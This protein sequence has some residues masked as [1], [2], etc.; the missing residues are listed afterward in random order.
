MDIFHLVDKNKVLHTQLRPLKRRLEQSRNTETG[1][2]ANLQSLNIIKTTDF[3]L[4]HYTHLFHIF[5]IKE[6][7]C[8]TNEIGLSGTNLT[9]QTLRMS[10][11]GYMVEI[12]LF[13][14][15]GHHIFLEQQDNTNETECSQYRGKL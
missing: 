3:C 1:L 8:L 6:V 7:H 12:I 10:S 15:F 2:K 14:G 9:R 13:S 11:G 4:V 5:F